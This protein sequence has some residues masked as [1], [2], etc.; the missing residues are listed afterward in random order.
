MNINKAVDKKW[1]T[2]TLTE[3]AGAPPSALEGITE[4]HDKLLAQLGIKT[5]RDLAEWKYF[6][7]AHA[8][9]ELAKLEQ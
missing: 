9:V 1:E 4:E 8:I 6:G 7:W 2:K 5:V 3:I